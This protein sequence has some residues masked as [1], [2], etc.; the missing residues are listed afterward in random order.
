MC[1]CHVIVVGLF[2]KSKIQSS[3]TLNRINWSAVSPAVFV[4]RVI[5]VESIKTYETFQ[6]QTQSV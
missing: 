5:C 4:M 2:I 3:S 1:V 6:G